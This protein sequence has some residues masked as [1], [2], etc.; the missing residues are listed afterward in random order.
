MAN[1]YVQVT[2]PST[3]GETADS[4]VNTFAFKSSGGLDSGSAGVYTDEI[5][6]F[7]D[8]LVTANALHGLAQNGWVVK[9]YNAVTTPGNYPLFTNGFNLA[10]A[11]GAVD[12]PLEVSLCVSYA[13]DS[14]TTVAP[15]RR[16]GRIY[17]SGWPE[18]VNTTGRPTSAAY[19]SLLNAYVNY[20]EGVNVLSGVDACIWS[21]ANN[22]LYE[23]ERVWVDNEWDTM[24]SRGG[25]STLRSTAMIS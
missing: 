4:Q 8:E 25:K 11:P 9:Y 22:A 13:N 23:I 3:T 20:V 14:E 17:V 10:T 24:R 7:Y 21:R 15:A 6:S 5:K 12:L 18:S 16:R 1:Y 19:D 2:G